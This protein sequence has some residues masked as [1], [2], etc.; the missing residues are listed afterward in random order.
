MG[1]YTPR[2]TKEKKQPPRVHSAVV[3]VMWLISVAI[4]ILDTYRFVASGR[5]ITVADLVCDIGI[6]AVAVYFT[7]RY[8]KENKK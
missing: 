2:I 8:A 6:L 4:L 3:L 5:G 7:V 1:K